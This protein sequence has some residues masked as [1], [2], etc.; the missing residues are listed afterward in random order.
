MMQSN[1]MRAA[2]YEHYGS[3][4]GL[5]IKYV[6]IPK[7]GDDEI[8]VRVRC[9][10]VNRTDC[11]FLRA[12]PFVV[13]FVAGLTKPRNNILG[14]E[15]AGEVVAVGS[16]VDNYQIGDRV[17]GFKDDDFGFG[18]HAEFTTMSVKGLLTKIPEHMSFETAAAALEGSH[19]ALQGINAVQVQKNQNVLIN[20]GTGSIGSAAVQIARSMGANVT[21]VCGTE[22]LGLVSE[23]G[24]HEVVDYQSEDFTKI[25]SKFDHVFD[26]VGKSTF[27]QCKKI[28]KPGGTYLSSELGPFCQ[29]P[30]LALVTPIF[31]KKRVHFPI[32]R[33][34]NE[35]GAYIGRLMQQKKYAPLID[36]SYPLDEIVDAFRYVETGNKIGNVILKIA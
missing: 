2:T 27:G 34:T 11:G 23:L 7:H 20:G 4:D 5:N 19:Y 29:N 22:H 36:R 26:A 24:A 16:E 32:P 15:F 10:T 6:P 25:H 9:S 33:N 17:C 13:R 8:L 12:K 28:I 31:G 35:D 1:Q 21:A 30:V 14:C 18:G 3:P